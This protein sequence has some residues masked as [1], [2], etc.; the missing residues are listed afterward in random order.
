MVVYLIADKFKSIVVTFII[1]ARRVNKF[2]VSDEI[3]NILGAIHTELFR[4][5]VDFF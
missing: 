1:N 4:F 3:S 5:A 2:A